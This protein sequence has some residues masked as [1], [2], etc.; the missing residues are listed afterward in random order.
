MGRRRWVTWGFEGGTP[1][2]KKP[3]A[4]LAVLA[5]A[6]APSLAGAQEPAKKESHGY[7]GGGLMLVSNTLDQGVGGGS[8]DSGGGGVFA[9]G[10]G[11]FDVGAVGIGLNGGIFGGERTYDDVDVDVA[12]GQFSMDG[13]VVL[14]DLLYL[15]LGV[16]SY[17]YTV[18]DPTLGDFTT[19]YVTV[20]L[21]VGVYKATDSGYLLAQVRAGGGTVTYEDDS[22]EDLGY[23]AIRFMGQVGAANGV[24]FLGGL[25]VESYDLKDSDLQDD[26]FRIFL[27]VAFGT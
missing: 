27:G 21:G 5:A 26:Y 4:V 7:G 3:F 13:G 19:S 17:A 14:F 2:T 18:E 15:T 25:E 1:V 23:F 24:Q 22:E 11:L 10:A 20:P 6:C 9:Y 16:Q 8:A 12:E